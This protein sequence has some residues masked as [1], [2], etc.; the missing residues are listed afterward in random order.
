MSEEVGNATDKTRM[1]YLAICM[2]LSKAPLY[3]QNKLL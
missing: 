3:M 2:L 1:K